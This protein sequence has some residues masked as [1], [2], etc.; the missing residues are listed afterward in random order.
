VGQSKFRLLH[1]LCWATSSLW[2]VP[3]YPFFVCQK[4]QNRDSLRF[5]L[6]IEAPW[7][8]KCVGKTNAHERVLGSVGCKPMLEDASVRDLSN[9]AEG[10]E[11]FFTKGDMLAAVG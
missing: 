8:W 5:E 9:K 10:K 3:G 7:L 6:L 2:L 11:R 1:G 4:S